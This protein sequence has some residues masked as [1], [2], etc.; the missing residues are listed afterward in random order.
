[1]M[2]VK[3]SDAIKM[4]NEGKSLKDVVLE[5][6]NDV[7]VNV[8]DAMPLSREGIVIPEANIFY[9]DTDIAYDEEIDG[10]EKIGKL[11]KMSQEE[12]RAFFEEEEEEN[13]VS[14][15]LRIPNNQMKSWIGKNSTRISDMLESILLS[16]YNAEERFK[17]TFT[18]HS[19]QDK[20]S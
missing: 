7:Q 15:K 6:I 17:N 1:M 2:K 11:R 18:Q 9:D 8:R 4:A 13:E 12:K 14:I 10:L 20:P 5:D 3:T 16:L 19:S